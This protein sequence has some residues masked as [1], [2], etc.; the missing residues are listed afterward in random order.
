MVKPS[1]IFKKL[2]L[3]INVGFTGAAGNKAEQQC[4]CSWQNNFQCATVIYHWLHCVSRPDSS[5]NYVQFNA[6][7]LSMQHSVGFMRPQRRTARFS[8]LQVNLHLAQSAATQIQFCV[9]RHFCFQ[10]PK[11]NIYKNDLMWIFNYSHRTKDVHEGRPLNTWIQ[12][13]Q[14]SPVRVRVLDILFYYTHNVYIYY[15]CITL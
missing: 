12:R 8:Y 11:A 2:T 13:V 3:E 14:W 6:I 1:N 9:M 7:K 10:S 15:L 5:L 4:W